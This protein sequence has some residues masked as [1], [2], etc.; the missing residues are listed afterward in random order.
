MELVGGETVEEKIARS[1]R[2]RGL[3]FD[4]VLEIAQQIAV[5]L[6]AAH[7]RG[8]V[9]R[10]LKPANIKVRPDGT[11]KVLDFGIAKALSAN[12]EET[13]GDTLTRIDGAL[14]GTPSYMSPEQASGADIDRRTDIWAFGCVLFE[15]LTGQRAFEGDTDSRILARVIEREPDWA[16]LSP[17]VPA[18]MRAL[19]RQCLEKDPRKRRR[20][21]GD[22]QLDLELVG[23]EPATEPPGSDARRGGGMRLLL[24]SFA[25]LAL[26]AA[27]AALYLR[28]TPAPEM[29]LQLLTPPTLLPQ[30]FALS[31]DGQYIA[32]VAGEGAGGRVPRLYLRPLDSTDAQEI[33]GTDGALY[34]FW[35]PDS[36]SI[37]FF[38]SETLYRVDVSGGP[39]QPL[40]PAPNPQG[41]TWGAD[42]TILF[43]PQTVSPLLSVPASGGDYVEATTL[44]SPYQQNHRFPSFLPDG[45]RFLF[46]AEGESEEWGIYLGSLDG[47]APRR[48]TASASAGVPVSPGHVVFVQEGQLVARP[49]DAERGVLTGEPVVLA[50]GVNPAGGGFFGFS[51]SSTGLLAYRAA[52]PPRVRSTWFDREGNVLEIGEPMNGPE[53]SPDD[54][55]VAYDM[56][57]DGNRDV[58]IQDLQRGG[59]TRY[60]T[61]LAV[62]GYPIWSPDGQQLVLES[63]RN[64]TFDLFI[65]PASRPGEEQLLI[66]TSDNEIP[67]AWSG[68]GR[69]VLYRKTD[70]DYRA[71]DLLAVS[72]LGDQEPV[73]VAGTPFEERM[74]AF[75]PDGRWVAYDTD[76]SGR[77][78]IVVQSFPEPS[79]IFPVSTDGGTGP[80]W[81]ADGSEIY[82]ASPNGELMA[83]R[84][85]MTAT[86][87]DAEQPI[88]LFATLI[89]PQTFNQQ[90]AVARDGR[91]L[92][93]EL[94]IG[95]AGA[96]I[97]LLLNWRP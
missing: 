33:A 75:S 1:T 85:T 30:H 77:F 19:L 43:T 7:Q 84:V 50:S 71:S 37:G 13:A 44:D 8:V 66:G 16:Q 3:P 27:S 5:A 41:G 59:A 48:L 11:V 93:N 76:R 51:A 64:G 21:A 97:T 96:P 57:I 95:D 14:I 89:L 94:Q 52:G 39:P 9:H 55:Y 6:D 20:D 65:G 17:E 81:S 54:R 10:D 31:P 70:D 29:R 26:F 56:T 87:F 73:V 24:A 15:M 28:E 32:F 35:S 45:R 38:A 23:T 25:I 53:V 68:D 69:Y 42:G 63:T 88:A 78:E 4:E 67:V 22:L 18:R 12:T 92:V 40:A 60:T 80:L 86:S 49:L 61:H 58:W 34:P 72:V 90:Y 82:F 47:G 62:D 36:N 91:F 79:E 74:G 83:A 2:G 46:Y